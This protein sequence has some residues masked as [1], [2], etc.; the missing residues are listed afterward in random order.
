MARTHWVRC[1]PSRAGVSSLAGVVQR[2]Q[3]ELIRR[4]RTLAA[5]PAE[6]FVASASTDDPLTALLVLLPTEALEPASRLAEMEALLE[7][8]RRC[9]VAVVLVGT[10]PPDGSYREVVVAADGSLAPAAA[11]LM[12]GARLL[13]TPSASEAA[14]VAASL[15]AREGDEVD[16]QELAAAEE[17]APEPEAFVEAEEPT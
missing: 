15:A 2:I 13:Y 12:G 17:G 5:L 4:E 14:V 6:D 10:A 1:S 7:Q 9:G 8:G 16:V 3:G 11:A